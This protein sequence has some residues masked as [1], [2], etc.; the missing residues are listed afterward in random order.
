MSHTVCSPLRSQ[1]VLNA[2]AVLKGRI[3][4]GPKRNRFERQN[5]KPFQEMFKLPASCRP[6]IM[7]TCFEMIHSIQMK[8]DPHIACSLTEHSTC[9]CITVRTKL[10]R[11]ELQHIK[12]PGKYASVPALQFLKIELILS[13]WYSALFLTVLTPIRP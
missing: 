10:Q 3:L 5:K 1:S 2:L 12:I 8:S 7:N 11:R 9:S 13:I 6:C 4:S